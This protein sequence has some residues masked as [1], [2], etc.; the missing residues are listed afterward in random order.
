[1]RSLQPQWIRWISVWVDRANKKGKDK[2]GTEFV[3]SNLN[4][5]KM[6]NFKVRNIFTMS[7]FCL[8][9]VLFWENKNATKH[10]SGHWSPS[11]LLKWRTLIYLFSR[12][13]SVASIEE[14][15]NWFHRSITRRNTLQSA[16]RQRQTKSRQL[17]SIVRYGTSFRMPR[18]WRSIFWSVKSVLKASR[19]CF[20]R[21]TEKSC[22]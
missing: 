10:N 20:L 22:L 13:A 11:S 7:L 15:R 19:K 4:T 5:G 18:A 16:S 12:F 1:M 8:L 2:T 17:L 6:R 21:N 14:F 3:L 9:S